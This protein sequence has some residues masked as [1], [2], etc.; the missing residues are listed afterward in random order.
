MCIAAIVSKKVSFF[1]LPDLVTIYI[2][3]EKKSKI[4]IELKIIIGII[5]LVL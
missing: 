1:F 3:I 2:I 5:D 4:G